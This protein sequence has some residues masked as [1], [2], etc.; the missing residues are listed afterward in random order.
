MFFK[1]VSLEEHMNYRTAL[2]EGLYNDHGLDPAQ[3][4][5]SIEAGY[6]LK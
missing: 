2:S 5:F 4:P 3:G 6:H 1:N